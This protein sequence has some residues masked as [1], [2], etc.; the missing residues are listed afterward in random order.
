MNG[1]VPR[2]ERPSRYALGS[3][4]GYRRLESTEGLCS[5]SHIEK[6]VEFLCKDADLTIPGLPDS[7]K[8]SL[9][10]KIVSIFLSTFLNTFY[11]STAQQDLMGHHLDIYMS[12]AKDL[13]VQKQMKELEE[14]EESGRKMVAVDEE[15]YMAPPWR[16]EHHQSQERPT[17]GHVAPSNMRF[18]DTIKLKDKRERA[19]GRERK[20]GQAQKEEVRHEGVNRGLGHGRVLLVRVA[21]EGARAPSTSE[22]SSRIGEGQ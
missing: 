17:K 22:C 10:S 11:N 3:Q 6:L 18:I 21:G 7:I 15:R 16:G 5:A 13:Q 14:E 20:K 9:Y 19:E 2:Q 4:E 12:N 1:N 8:H